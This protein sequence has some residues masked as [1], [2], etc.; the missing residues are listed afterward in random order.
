MASAQPVHTIALKI[1]Q[2]NCIHRQSQ[3]FKELK[4]NGFTNVHEPNKVEN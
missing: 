2:K 1:I 3:I 4:L